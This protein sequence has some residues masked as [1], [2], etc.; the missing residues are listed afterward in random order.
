MLVIM[1]ALSVLCLALSFVLAI[2]LVTWAI[3]MGV[4]ITVRGIISY[5]RRSDYSESPEFSE[6]ES[7]AVP[8]HR[9]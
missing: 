5:F 2:F 7:G 1:F 3:V 6:F 4:I 9:R 8:D